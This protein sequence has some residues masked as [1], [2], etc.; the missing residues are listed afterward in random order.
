MKHLIYV[1]LTSD[2]GFDLNELQQFCLDEN[3][4]VK[5][6]L[7][8]DI[9]LPLFEVPSTM[10]SQIHSIITFLGALRQEPLLIDF[11]GTDCLEDGLI[12]T[13]KA[14][15][16]ITFSKSTQL[17]IIDLVDSLKD[18]FLAKFE[19]LV[20]LPSAIQLIKSQRGFKCSKVF[21]ADSSSVFSGLDVFITQNL[22]F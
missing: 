22:T 8:G 14:S 18:V 15:W 12:L 6:D 10:A 1:V 7:V 19:D 4:T 16:D 13:P 9:R 5:V 21:G 2:L 11:A 17:I 20:P 3:P